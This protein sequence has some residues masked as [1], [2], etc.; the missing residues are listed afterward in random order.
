MQ[1]LEEVRPIWDSLYEESHIAEWSGGWVEGSAI[2]FA[3]ELQLCDI[4]FKRNF[5]GL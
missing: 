1:D 5:E 3:S 4:C 2:V